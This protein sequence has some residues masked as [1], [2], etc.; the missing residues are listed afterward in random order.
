MRH[1][2]IRLF[3]FKECVRC[4]QSAQ[5]VYFIFYI[6]LL[7]TMYAN[8]STILCASESLSPYI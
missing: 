2:G 4:E 6:Q 5:K 8:I 3:N 1:T 7:F